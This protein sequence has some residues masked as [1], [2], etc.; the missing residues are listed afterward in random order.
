M[1]RNSSKMW[2]G[3]WLPPHPRP[4]ILGMF[5]PWGFALHVLLQIKKERKKEISCNFWESTKPKKCRKMRS[6]SCQVSF[7]IP[8]HLNST[9]QTIK[10]IKS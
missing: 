3:T 6:K 5:Q 9:K 4:L 7:T 2:S 1:D 10:K 8:W